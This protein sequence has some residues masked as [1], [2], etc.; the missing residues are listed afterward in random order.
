MARLTRKT[1]NPKLLQ[2]CTIFTP[3]YDFRP[4]SFWK[5]PQIYSRGIDCHDGFG[6]IV[7]RLRLGRKQVSFNDPRHHHPNTIYL[8]S[9]NGHGEV[10]G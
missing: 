1:S 2:P 8:P 10:R 9:P 6:L 5:R 7:T 3:R 4:G